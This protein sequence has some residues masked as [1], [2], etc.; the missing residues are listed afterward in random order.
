MAWSSRRR[1][2]VR[3]VAIL[4][5][6]A[7]FA[8]IAGALIL[9][10]HRRPL[11]GWE[12]FAI[13]PSF[14]R[15]M[16]VDMNMVRSEGITLRSAISIAYEIPVVRVIGPGWLD[17]SRYTITAT[18]PTAGAGSMRALLRQELE[19][20]L[21]LR[22]RSEVRPFDVLVLTATDPSRLQRADR[23]MSR[24]WIQDSDARIEDA[25]MDAVAN[26][27]QG[28]LGKPVVNETG[29]TDSYDLEFGW[30][31]DRLESVT[32]T[33]QRRFGL[34]LTPA[35]RDLEALVV[36]GMR[37]DASLVLIAGIDQLARHAPTPFRRQLAQILTLR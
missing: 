1:W 33:L 21:R 37:R 11:P 2:L 16:T 28:I 32:G 20:R 10:T 12:T 25:T 23:R 13:G 8:I 24:V 30:G 17:Y 29:L 19:A 14:G 5:G 36:E 26:A 35:R 22:T 31:K 27:L 15:S 18:V 34:Q 9:G 3:G 6:T 4:A 7:A